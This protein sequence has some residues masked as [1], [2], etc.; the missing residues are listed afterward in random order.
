MLVDLEEAPLAAIEARAAERS[1]DPLEQANDIWWALYGNEFGYFRNTADNLSS[2]ELEPDTDAFTWDDARGGVV[3][4]R[5]W[6]WKRRRMTD[7][8]WMERFERIKDAT[9]H[10]VPFV[11]NDQ[12][13]VMEAEV[14]KAER[15]GRPI[16]LW[17][18]KVRQIGA[19]TYAELRAGCRALRNANLRA[20]LVAHR[21]K[22]AAAIFGKLHT[23]RKL[24][25]RWNGSRWDFATPHKSR[26]ELIFGEPISSAIDID[27]AE[28]DEPGHGETID[29]LHMTETAR[30]KDADVKAKGL[31][32]TVPEEPH[33]VIISESTA[34]GDDGYF[35]DTFWRNYDAPGSI[36]VKQREADE[37]DWVALFFPW[38]GFKKYRWSYAHKK[39]LPELLRV[40][41]ENSLDATEE[42]LLETS[43]FRRGVGWCRVDIDQLAWRREKKRKS[44]SDSWQIFNEQYPGFPEDAFIASG[45]I[46]FDAERVRALIPLCTAPVFIGDLIEHGTG[47][48]ELKEEIEWEAHD[49]E[50]RQSANAA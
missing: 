15:D 48:E 49:G 1:E 8:E 20:L 36:A 11:L 38:Y 30:W 41:I 13:R 4:V 12:Q 17:V 10:I 28:V 2:W 50:H 40:Q 34:N 19:S 7:V 9:N 32:Q 46:A 23:M 35:R 37:Q 22:T 5:P 25:P 6:R 39:P 45:R 27:S 3:V 42:K 29:F 44:C 33:T 16:R 24:M 47:P 14:L 18:L 21:K 43:Y 31:E 26:H